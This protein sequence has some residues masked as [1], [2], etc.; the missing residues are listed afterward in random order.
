MLEFVNDSSEISIIDKSTEYG[1]NSIKGSVAAQKS[2]MSSN[3]IAAKRVAIMCVP[4]LHSIIK[5]P[6]D[7]I[8]SSFKNLIM[9]KPIVC[10][11]RLYSGFRRKGEYQ[12]QS[13]NMKRR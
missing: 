3:E 6:I 5:E 8:V 11:V 12:C 13:I 9:I 7:R 1:D 2:L 10:L 4:L